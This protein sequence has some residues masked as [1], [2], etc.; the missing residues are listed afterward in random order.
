MAVDAAA[1][2]RVRKPAPK[3]EGAVSEKP[4]VS[5]KGQTINRRPPHVLAA[6]LRKQRDKLVEAH[7]A[8]LAKID[9]RIAHFEE[10]SKGM[11][12]IVNMIEGGETPESIAAEIQKQMAAARQLAK[13]LK[14]YQNTT[15]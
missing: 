13:T 15:K 2:P 3:A 1:R 12:E 14:K 10:R 9:G 7:E 6:E 8:R 4:R 11:I 5:R